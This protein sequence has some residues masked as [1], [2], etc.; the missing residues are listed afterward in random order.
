MKHRDGQYNAPV[1]L[2]VRVGTLNVGQEKSTAMQWYDAYVSVGGE[3]TFNT[4]ATHYI[5]TCPINETDFHHLY[6]LVEWI[7]EKSKSDNIEKE[8]E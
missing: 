3:H 7:L 5:S 2:F 8:D 4:G 6:G 1:T